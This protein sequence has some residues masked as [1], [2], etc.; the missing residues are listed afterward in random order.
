MSSASPAKKK[1]KFLM[2]PYLLLLPPFILLCAFSFYPFA[3]TVINSFSVTDEIGNWL[4]WAGL[5]Q[6]KAVLTDYR[7]KGVMGTTFKFAGMNLVFTMICSMFLAL[8]GAKKGRGQKLVTVLYAL[9]LSISHAA[10]AAIWKI[11][12]ASE[13]AGGIINTVLG[14]DISFLNTKGLA[15]LCVSIAT[16]W[17]HIASCYILLLAGFRNVSDDLIEAATLDGANGFVKAT[18]I[19]IPIASPQIFYVLFVTIISSFTTFT[20]IKLLTGGSPAY[21]TVNIT[22]EIFLR[23]SS[24]IE[25]ACVYSVILFLIVFIVTRIQFFFEKKIVFYK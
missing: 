14:T 3:R 24:L 6:W 2:T 17:T 5:V 7:F 22:Y 4:G 18:R 1:R 21:T 16:T 12:Y 25:T 20:Q 9:P 10:A 8:I 13:S 19:M 23:S 11:W 15:L